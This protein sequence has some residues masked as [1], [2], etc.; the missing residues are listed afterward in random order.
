MS[1]SSLHLDAFVEVARQKSF[2]AAAEK[3][4]ITQSALS[5]RVLNLEKEI[6]NSLF[7]RESS[8]L[9][10]T[11]LGEKLL[12]YCQSKELLETEFLQHLQPGTSKEL[13]G[14]LRMASFST[15]T[16]SL[17]IP[18]LSR[19][20]MKYPHVQYDVKTAELQDL[21]RLLSSGQ[22]DFIFS[23]S[24]IE[25]QG[26]ESHLIGHEVNVLV[27]STRKNIRDHIYLDHDSNDQT[28]YEFFKHQGQKNIQIQR[29]YMGDIESIL[30]AVQLGLGLAV[31]PVHLLNEQKGLEQIKKYKSLRIPIYFSFYKMP[32]YTELHKQVTKMVLEELP[33]QLK[34]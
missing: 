15:F 3:L 31:I 14:I 22:V 10:L 29:N 26:I 18:F 8:G 20:A 34:D 23:N 6:G 25:K 12:R 30:Q 16:N 5:Q 11:D 32:F 21:P 4:F 27:K 2:S 13:G 24:P 17:L 9:R 19:F 1:L 33:A 7:I 28:T